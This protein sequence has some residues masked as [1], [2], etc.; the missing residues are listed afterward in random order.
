LQKLK[1]L[2]NFRILAAKLGLPIFELPFVVVQFDAP[3]MLHAPH[4]V[5]HI[6]LQHFGRIWTFCL[7]VQNQN[8]PPHIT[9]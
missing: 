2:K 4:D 3:R 7:V 1:A 5:H 8:L 6:L 9:A